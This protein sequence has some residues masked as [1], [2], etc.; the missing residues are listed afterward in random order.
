MYYKLAIVL[1]LVSCAV[2]RIPYS[3]V[4][5]TPWKDCGSTNVVI[6]NVEVEGCSASP[7]QLPKG[8]NVSVAITFTPK[9]AFTDLINKLYGLIAGVAVPF[10][11]PEADACKLG[12]TC[13]MAVGT[14][15]V[16]TV[17][18]YIDPAWPSIQVIGE[19]KI[20][21]PNSVVDGC[22]EVPLKIV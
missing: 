7:C 21:D 9:Q 15:Y 5:A 14:Q 8:T 19:W 3:R 12:V 18:L 6:N 16:E 13:P 10:P 20:D 2:A 11:L 17:A 22:F 4:R 1:A